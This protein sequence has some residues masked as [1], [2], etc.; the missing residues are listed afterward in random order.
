MPAS[1][2]VWRDS[3]S[4]WPS[5][6]YILGH[7][8]GVFREVFLEQSRELTCLCIVSRRIGPGAA[9]IAHIARH[10]RSARGHF[11]PE[12]RVCLGRDIVEQPV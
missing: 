4:Q 2:N 12:H 5:T 11:K 10:T 8:L 6:A 9:G 3:G 7:I 1:V